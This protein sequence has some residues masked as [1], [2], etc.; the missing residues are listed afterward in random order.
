ML[1]CVSTDLEKR[2]CDWMKAAAFAYGVEPTIECVL[3]N[4]PMCM[5]AAQ[6]SRVDIL[7]VPP[8]ELL[9]ARK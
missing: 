2:K 1:W 9:E 3:M 8:E 5:K 6:I 4:R 7:M